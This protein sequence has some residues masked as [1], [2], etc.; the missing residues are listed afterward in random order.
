MTKKTIWAKML[1]IASFTGRKYI[2]PPNTTLN[3]KFSI[4]R[5]IDTSTLPN[6]TMRYLAIGNG[7]VNVIQNSADL[8]LHTGVRKVKDGA[9]FSHVPFIIRDKEIGFTEEEKSKYRLMREVNL[10][11][12]TYIM[13][14]LKILNP[15]DNDSKL[16]T[17][18]TNGNG[19]MPTIEVFTTVDS[20]ILYP[21]DDRQL[22]NQLYTGNKYLFV[23]D[24]I[25]ITLSAEEMSNI[26]EAITTLGLDEVSPSIN[27]MALCTGIEYTDAETGI[28]ETLDAQIAF[29]IELTHKLEME[30]NDGDDFYR[31]IDIGGMEPMRLA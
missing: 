5:N 18:E 24:T 15:D 8:P 3:E 17:I 12:K 23:A 11:D 27:E 21:V 30:L 22:T 31:D 13:F 16:M 6:P 2:P 29:F 9:L 25:P 14:M 26:Q 19:S 10:G 7:N 28:V 1:E 20:E 4:L